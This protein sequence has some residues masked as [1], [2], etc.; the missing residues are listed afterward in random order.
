M[1]IAL[2]LLAQ[3]AGG[4]QAFE[5]SPVPDAVLAELRGGIQLPNGIDL[6]LTVQTQTAV[7]GA[8]V[9]QTVFSLIDGS[10]ELVVY[11]PPAGQTVAAEPV[12]VPENAGPTGILPTVTYDSRAGRVQVTPGLATMPVA[13]G[14]GANASSSIAEG[15]E[16]VA[17][18]SAT[19]SGVIGQSAQGALRA[20]SLTGGNL[21]VTHFAGGAFGSAIANSGSD[22]TISTMTSVSIDLRNAGPDVLGSAMLRMEDVALGALASRL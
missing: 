6:A 2:L 8:I 7:D 5:A 11:A 19:D 18:G 10:P 3:A 17:A 1:S 4:A 12:A 13:V 16:R 14:S 21:S 22:R 9:L 20:I 15:L